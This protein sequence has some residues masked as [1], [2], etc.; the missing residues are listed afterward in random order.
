MVSWDAPGDGGSTITSYTVVLCQLGVATSFSCGW[1][2]GP[3]DC[4]IPDVDDG[5]YTARVFATNA[6]GNGATSV[7]SDVVTVPD[8]P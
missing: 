7:D 4:D 5:A 2:T 8:G 1:T 3:L 6:L